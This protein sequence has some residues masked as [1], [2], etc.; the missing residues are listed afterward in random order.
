M[1]DIVAPNCFYTVFDGFANFGELSY[2]NLRIQ[3]LS[4]YID[5]KC[6]GYWSKNT[7]QK[8]LQLTQS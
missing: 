1:S 7:F 6:S 8:E 5:K 2:I 3:E 4:H